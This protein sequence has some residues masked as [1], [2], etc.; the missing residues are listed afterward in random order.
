M[1]E[2]CPP[3]E[4]PER[5]ATR[6]ISKLNSG[7]ADEAIAEAKDLALKAGND[8]LRLYDIACVYAVAC[9]AN[10]D[11]QVEYGDLAMDFLQRSLKSGL[12][13]MGPL[14][15]DEELDPIR[16]REDFKKLIDKL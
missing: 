6:A 15:Q 10:A 3:D 5:R 4:I 2:L 7:K 1:L 8:P 14:K 12:K 16:S 11:K 13:E 9:G